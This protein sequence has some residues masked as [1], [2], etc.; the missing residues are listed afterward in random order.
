M[1]KNKTG[2]ITSVIDMDNVIAYIIRKGPIY[3]AHESRIIFEGEQQDEGIPNHVQ[4]KASTTAVVK[5]TTL[6]VTVVNLIIFFLYNK[7]L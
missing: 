3:I 6:L 1:L 5:S 2:T 7:C 4:N